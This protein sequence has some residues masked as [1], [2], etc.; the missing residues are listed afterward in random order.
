MK[1]E[2]KLKI[3][4]IAYIGILLIGFYFIAMPDSLEGFKA[5]FNESKSANQD[6][7]LNNTTTLQMIYKIFS[8]ISALTISYLGISLL[9]TLFRFIDSVSKREIFTPQNLRRLTI[10]GWYSIGICVALLLFKLTTYF[11]NNVPYEPDFFQI[12]VRAAIESVFWLA[13]L[14]LVFL[15]I[16][17]AFR[18]G[19][20]IQEENELT[21]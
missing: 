8:G 21:V 4:K 9:I 15:T 19:I 14:G 1:T 20:E 13:V 11:A 7:S 17:Y 18:K 6:I 2:K 12:K 10:C 16:G 3:F 5:G